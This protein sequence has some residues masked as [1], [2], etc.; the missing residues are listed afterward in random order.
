MLPTEAELA[1]MEKEAASGSA[2][3]GQ[4]EAKTT[5]SG[6]DTDHTRNS[7]LKYVND[8]RDRA[9]RK[10][11]RSFRAHY[12]GWLTDGRS[13]TLPRSRPD[14]ASAGQGRVIGDGMKALLQ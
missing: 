7:G 14:F 12:T 8:G 6:G 1:G 11:V 3:V 13:S 2:P 5:A 9:G 10:P 4:P